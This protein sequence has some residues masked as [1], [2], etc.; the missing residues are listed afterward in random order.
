MAGEVF[1]ATG[2]RKESVSKIKIK[3][4]KG[5]VT[6]NG[7]DINSYLCRDNLVMQALKPLDVAE[8]EGRIIIECTVRGGGL[9]GQ[10]GAISLGLARALTRFDP[11]LRSLLKR[12]GLLRRDPRM[13]E[14]KKYGQ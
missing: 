4:G 3:S 5:K 6:V 9:S 12:N 8:L 2:R 11:E 13:V 7:R 10:A 14:R 1:T